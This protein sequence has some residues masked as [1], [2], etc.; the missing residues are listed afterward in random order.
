MVREWRQTSV[1][2]QEWDYIP[3]SD[4]RFSNTNSG[5]GIFRLT[6][7]LFLFYSYILLPSLITVTVAILNDEYV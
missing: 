5:E 2:I 1:A 6:P 4:A 7:P 3:T